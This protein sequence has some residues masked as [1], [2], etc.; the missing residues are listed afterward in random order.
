MVCKRANVYNPLQP[1]RHTNA[2]IFFDNGSEKS[3]ISKN[4]SKK[5]NLESIATKQFA[6]SG[7]SG[8]NIGKYQGKVYNL[9]VCAGNFSHIAEVCELAKVVTT[10]PLVDISEDDA[11]ELELDRLGSL[12]ETTEPD[13]LIGIYSYNQFGIVP[14]REFCQMGSG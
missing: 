10:L 1:E 14:G 11:K 4:L 2:V 6:V 9:G 7:L 12:L 13:I 8:T 3:Y 5:L